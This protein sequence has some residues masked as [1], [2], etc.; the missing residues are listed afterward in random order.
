M[1]CRAALAVTEILCNG[2]TCGVF[3]SRV[4]NLWLAASAKF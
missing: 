1:D 3:I 4:F 2:E